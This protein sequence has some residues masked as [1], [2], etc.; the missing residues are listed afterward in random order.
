MLLPIYGYRAAAEGSALISLSDTRVSYEKEGEFTMVLSAVRLYTG[1]ATRNRVRVGED[2][3]MKGGE[4]Y[5]D[6]K[7]LQVSIAEK[8]SPRP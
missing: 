5:R 1:F 4:V 2:T 3:G 7:I 8:S 6:V